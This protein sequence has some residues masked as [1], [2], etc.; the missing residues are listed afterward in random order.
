[1]EIIKFSNIQVLLSCSLI[2]V[3]V[4][5]TTLL[6]QFALH[7]TKD[8]QIILNTTDPK[9]KFAIS[10]LNHKQ[11]FT[12]FFLYRTGTSRTDEGV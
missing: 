11:G 4:H 2:H 1:M 8:Y 5:P 3:H 7:W 10:I 12:S 6:L 9:K